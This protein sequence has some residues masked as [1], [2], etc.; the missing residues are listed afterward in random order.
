MSKFDFFCLCFPYSLCF[1]CLK[2]FRV[3][4][5]WRRLCSV[6]L[7][8]VG[9]R[10]QGA[11]SVHRG[12]EIAPRV[13]RLSIEG[14]KSHTGCF[15]ALFVHFCGPRIMHIQDLLPGKR[16]QCLCLPSSSISYNTDV[17]RPAVLHGFL[18]VSIVSWL[19]FLAR[20]NHAHYVL[21]SIKQRTATVTYY[22]P[23]LVLES[24]PRFAK[25]GKWKSS[26]GFF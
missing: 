13:L 9:N 25:K 8:G 20:R 4:G 1:V 16:S 18:C 21:A 2:N 10:T 15:G 11:S 7:S 22:I 24:C 26:L 19:F 5:S 3:C 23:K 6:C 14:Q 12:S 17:A